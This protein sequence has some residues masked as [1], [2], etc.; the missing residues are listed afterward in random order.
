MLEHFRS[1]I[2]KFLKFIGVDYVRVMMACGSFQGDPQSEHR[3]RTT[4]T[5][6]RTSSWKAENA[7]E[8][9]EQ[10]VLFVLYDFLNMSNHA[11]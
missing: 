2:A 4:G 11:P 3:I 8:L 1:G 10:L 5:M 7:G 6:L 9:I